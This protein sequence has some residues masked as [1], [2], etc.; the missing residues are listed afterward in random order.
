MHLLELQCRD[1]LDFKYDIN[2]QENILNLNIEDYLDLAIRNNK[3]RRFLFVSK[4]LGKHLPCK[5]MDMD[6]LG[7]D[8]VRAYEKKQDYLN[9]G[10]VISFAETGTALGHSVF[11]Y[12]NAD[13]EFIH[14]TRERLENKKSLEFLEEHSH[15]TNHN[16]YYEDLKRFESG[17]EIVLVDDEI[18]TGN[19]CINLIRKINSIYPKKRYTICSI[20]NWMDCDAFDRFKNLENEIDAKINF[21][22]LFAGDFKFECDEDKVEKLILESEK[23]CKVFTKNK[24]LKVSYTY[25]DMKKYE[26]NEKYIKYTGRFGINKKDQNNLLEDVRRES[27]KLEVKDREKTLFL[28]SEE[29]MYIPMLFAKQFEGKNIYYHSTTR[30][31]IVDLAIENYPIKSKFPHNSIYNR[32][33]Q[34]YVY[35][36]DKYNYEKCFFFCE[37]NREKNDF[38]EII[39]IISNTGIKE[40]NIVICNK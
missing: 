32:G 3:K 6:K 25:L 22:Y 31:P 39:N 12:I 38:D 2:I 1:E 17:E 26:K 16:L 35:N 14:T 5:A 19:T 28:G 37:L 20:L 30:S 29:F 23:E 21:V 15:A 24:D 34:N 11:N 33:V 9:S 8:I 4:C 10:L 27:K 40:L 13:Y 7:Y 18:T 36:I